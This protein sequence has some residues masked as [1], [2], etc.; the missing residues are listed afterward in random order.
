MSRITK[1]SHP[2]FLFFALLL[3]F[4]LALTPAPAIV[5]SAPIP[6]DQIVLQPA[7]DYLQSQQQADGGIL[8]F[9]GISDPDTTARV[10]LALAVNRLPVDTLKS[11]DGKSLLDYLSSQAVTYTHDPNQLLFPGRAG[12]LL[13]AAAVAGS[14]GHQFGGMDLVSELTAAYHSETGVYSTTA[15]L[16]YASGAPSDLNQAWTILAL[17]LA[18]QPVPLQATF[19]LAASQAG[20]GSWGAGDPDT[21]ALVVTALLASRNVPADDPMIQKTIQ[22]FRTTQLE[23][24]GWRPSWDQDP[25]NADS[26][27]WILQALTSAGQTPPQ[28]SW[29][30]ASGTSPET[31]L[32]GL[33]KPDGS[34]GGTYANTYSTADALIGLGLKPL[35]GLG[36]PATF[37]RAGLVVQFGDG[38][39]YTACIAF[40]EDSISGIQLLQHSG[41]KLETV[42]DPSLG[43][44]VCK[45]QTDGCPSSQCFCSTP[46]YWSFWQ[47]ADSGWA[48]ASAGADQSQ[49]QDGSIQ[50]WSW[51]TGTAPAILTFQQVCQPGSI[52]PST[53]AVQPTSAP[54]QAAYPA[55]QTQSTSTSQPTPYPLTAEETQPAVQTT[56]APYPLP[57]ASTSPTP[58]P[59]SSIA[60][61]I[62]S[63]KILICALTGLLVIGLA[64]MVIFLARRRKSG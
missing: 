20:D 25:L 11:A 3:G 12:L 38:H 46:T 34:I 55:P 32:A 15:A 54:T 5:Q 40:T 41:L 10:I 26:T 22:Y 36:L 62:T 28:V 1:D 48:Y 18:G 42:T 53:V 16:D 33:Q 58:L 49:V 56:A 51:S 57:V 8:G 50:A 19:Y 47:P 37:H 23:S 43:S 63:G 13:A 39:L 45:I 52:Q 9:S 27:G 2:I 21:T 59:A 61:G 44:A 14:D 64:A 31:A 60:G 17:A 6:P 35:S 7:L 29:A 24:G 4:S 30:A